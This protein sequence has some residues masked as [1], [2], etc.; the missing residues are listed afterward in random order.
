MR[1][2]P[3][4]QQRVM[5][6]A[7]TPRH[8]GE[9]RDFTHR[10]TGT[11]PLCGDEITLFAGSVGGTQV[12]QFVSKGCALC[13]ASASLMLDV[14]LASPRPAWAS[15]APGPELQEVESQF[16]SRARCVRLP[17]ETFAQLLR[18]LP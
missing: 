10:R 8:H 12:L 13:R 11:N 4:Y 15:L 7:K 2:E 5:E 6:H 1:D 16:P 3:V 9:L 17:W 18:E 14:V